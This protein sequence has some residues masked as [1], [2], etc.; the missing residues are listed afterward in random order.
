MMANF[1]RP[2][3]PSISWLKYQKMAIEDLSQILRAGWPA[4][5]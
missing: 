5:T 1:E 3:S 2:S 4:A